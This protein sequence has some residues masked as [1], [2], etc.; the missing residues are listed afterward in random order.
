MPTP[1]LKKI[2]KDKGKSVSEM[3]DL[4]NQ[5]KAQA[6]KEGHAKDY[7]YITGIFKK[8]AGVTSGNL[9]TTSDYESILP[10]NLG[11]LDSKTADPNN[12]DSQGNPIMTKTNAIKAYARLQELSELQEFRVDYTYKDPHGGTAS[13][14]IKRKASD[15]EAAKKGA[16]L[17]LKRQGKQGF[18]IKKAVKV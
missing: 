9:R 17:Y 8:M 7:A 2:A 15:A 1:Y 10:S 3:E 4:W 12:F 13:G 16:S 6:A 18:S 5:A 11:L 14:S